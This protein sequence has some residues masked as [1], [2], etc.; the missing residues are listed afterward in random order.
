MGYAIDFVGLVHF[1]HLDSNAG[2]IVMLPDGSDPEA[3]FPGSKIP[4]H[5]AS[6]FVASDCVIKEQTRWWTPEPNEVFEE[7]GISE[8]PIP[9]PSRITVSG[10]NE[11]P[12]CWPFGTDTFD[13]NDHDKKVPGLAR[14]DPNFRIVPEKAAT[15]VQMPMRR[16]KLTAYSFGE[17]AAVSRLDVTKH[18]GPIMITARTD[19][20]KTMRTLVLKN[21]TEI[22]LS[23][24]SDLFSDDPYEETVSHFRLY[25]QLDIKRRY[26]MLK[27][28]DDSELDPLVSNHPYLKLISEIGTIPRP[29]C[30]NTCC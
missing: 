9:R 13:P 10:L 14:Q 19:D 20:G 26:E 11:N 23:N 28:P 16:G 12:G 22:V 29:G 2:R 27:D 5:Y 3:D 8:F 15:V 1:F 7:N 30:S 18:K 24:T 25:A 4:R 21:D 6:F 17:G